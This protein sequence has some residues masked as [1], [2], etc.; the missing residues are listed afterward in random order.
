[1][2]LYKLDVLAVVFLSLQPATGTFPLDDSCTA[3]GGT[4][5]R[6]AAA[7]LKTKQI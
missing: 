5:E 3:Q 1:M 7:F 2:S 4:E 6:A